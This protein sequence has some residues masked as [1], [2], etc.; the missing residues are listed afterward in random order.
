[1][2][3]APVSTTEAAQPGGTN[4]KENEHARNDI[5]RQGR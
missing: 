3:K 2:P 4:R 1:M 5:R